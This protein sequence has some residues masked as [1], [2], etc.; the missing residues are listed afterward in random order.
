[1]VKI[2]RPDEPAVHE[3]ILLAPGALRPAR[4]PHKPLN[5]HDI[6]D[7]LNGQQFIG[8]LLPQRFHHPFLGRLAAELVDELTIVVI[9]KLY[10]WVGH[11]LSQKLFHDV[12]GF[13]G[14]TLEEIPA[15]R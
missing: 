3:K 1:M 10:V 8:L 11:G 12:L 5:L 9:H 15:S 4:C 7:F 6:G 14:D 2:A 13:H